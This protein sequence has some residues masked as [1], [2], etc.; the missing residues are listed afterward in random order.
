MRT[1]LTFLRDGVLGT[2]IKQTLEAQKFQVISESDT[3]TQT[4]ANLAILDEADIGQDSTDR[5]LERL[6]DLQIPALVILDIETRGGN[7]NREHKQIREA[8]LA[9]FP[10]VST[11]LD[12]S[13]VEHV[14]AQAR[15]ALLRSNPPHIHIIEDDPDFL[16]ATQALLQAHGFVTS[17]S[18]TIREA[19]AA[20]QAGPIDVLIVDRQ[21]PDGDG[22]DF[23]REL[24]ELNILTPAIVLTVWR[25]VSQQVD[26]I[27]AGASDYITKPVED[28]AVLLARI[29][30]ALRGRDRSKLLSFGGLE[31]DCVNNLTRWRGEKLQKLTNRDQEVLEYIAAR[32]GVALPLSV[33]MEDIWGRPSRETA[34]LPANERHGP[35]IARRQAIKTTFSKAGLPDPIVQSKGT[36]AFNAEPFLK[37][38]QDREVSA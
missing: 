14:V 34:Q 9:V 20:F 6:A 32:H 28:E 3:V 36:Y 8:E 17:T 26:G 35:L 16:Q 31:I 2:E 22:V 30:L 12:P 18:E 7:L 25:D 11:M 21:L 5:I 4:D 29:R 1:V 15:A 10:L 19:R 38:G 13:D 23:I 24:R 27:E 33:I 37:L